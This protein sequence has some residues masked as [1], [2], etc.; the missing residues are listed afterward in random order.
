MN[1]MLF[2]KASLMDQS[3]I[4]LAKEDPEIRQAMAPFVR[5]AKGWDNMPKGWTAESVKKFW[6]SLTGEAKHKVTNCI[7]KMKS[8]MD[9]PGG[10]CAS[11]ADQ[12]D[13]GWR[14]RPRTASV[15]NQ[16]QT[17]GESLARKY[18]EAGITFGYIGNVRSSDDDD[19]SWKFFTRIPKTPFSHQTM[20]FGNYSTEDL[21]EMVVWAK[22]NLERMIQKA[23]AAS[24]SGKTSASVIPPRTGPADPRVDHAVK[25]YVIYVQKNL[26][27]YHSKHFPTLGHPVLTVENGMR[28][29]RIVKSDEGSHR[30]VFGFVDRNTGDILKAAS[31]K[32]PAAIP[33]GNVLDKTTWERSHSPWGVAYVR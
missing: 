9:N 25:E 16:L 13:P 7:E 10:F 4:R 24:S 28:F 14:S 23:L 31:W 32:A 17:F 19:R 29:A 30:S 2:R 27:D 22:S 18:P 6:G 33:R 5:E 12:V 11:I 3:F 8:H 15:G 1:T 26:D 21:P 20:S